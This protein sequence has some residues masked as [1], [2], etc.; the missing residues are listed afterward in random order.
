MN[1]HLSKED[2]QVANKHMKQCSVSLIIRE[3]QIKTTMR[4]HFTL[5]RMAIIKKSEG[6]TCWQRW[7]EKGPLY[8]VGGNVNQYSHHGKQ[9]W[10]F[11]KK[12]ELELTYDPA[13]PLLGIYQMGINH[14]LKEMAA[15]SRSLQHQSQ[16]PRYENNLSVHW[17]VNG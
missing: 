13:I 9:C 15:H 14:C 12:T 16:Q 4:Y 2:I 3:M 7:G 8:T 1:R 17:Q 6:N 11:L 10:W 5:I